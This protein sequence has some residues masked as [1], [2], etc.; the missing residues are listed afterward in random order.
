MN[1][2]TIYKKLEKETKKGTKRSFD[3]ERAKNGQAAH[4]HSDGLELQELYGC[5]SDMRKHS[6]VHAG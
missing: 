4:S 2:Y 3:Q 1:I 5:F 6:Q